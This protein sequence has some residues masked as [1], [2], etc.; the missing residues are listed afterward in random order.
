[1]LAGPRDVTLVATSS[2]S[3][4]LQRRQFPTAI[5]RLLIG[6]SPRWWRFG[7]GWH[8]RQTGTEASE[9][10]SGWVTFWT[11]IGAVGTC[12]AVFVGMQAGADSPSGNSSAPTAV[13]D[14]FPSESS[15]I[16][17]TR[18]SG[19]VYD[20]TCSC[21]EVRSLPA[22]AKIRLICSA[23]GASLT[24]NGR[25]STVWYRVDGGYVSDVLVNTN[26]QFNPDRC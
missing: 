15:D 19:Y 26:T 7:D 14:E 9:P 8:V 6:R 4:D 17:T 1:L 25:S 10:M 3:S 16:G 22:G 5:S 12:A 11:A 18:F 13:A 2:P 21:N 20:D 24:K 23:Q